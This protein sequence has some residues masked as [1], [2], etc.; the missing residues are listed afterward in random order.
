MLI[1]FSRPLICSIVVL[2]LS[3]A[4]ALAQSTLYAD[5]DAPPGGDGLSWN[6]AYRFLQDALADAAAS[7]G[8]ITE[9]RVAQGTYLPDRDEVNPGGDP[10]DC[11]APNGSPGCD[12]PACE[13]DV[14]AALAPCCVIDWD[15]NC[16]A[17]AADLCGSQCADPRL[18]T[19]QLLDGVSVVGGYA[20]LG[21]PDP[22][23]RLIE[24]YVTVLSGDILG[25][26]DTGGTNAENCYHVV[27]GSG[28]DATAVL[29]GFTVTAGN[30]NGPDP[31][32]SAG[33]GIVIASGDPTISQCWIT[34]NAAA[35]VGG[36][37]SCG[38]ASPTIS[39]CIIEANVA[40]GAIAVGGA[41]TNSE[42]DPVLIECE[43]IGN[44]ASSA[45][46]I[47]NYLSN[48]TF[49]GCR[50]EGNI[51]TGGD[52]G[53]MTNAVDSNPVL[54]DCQFI[55]NTA[56]GWGG[57]MLNYQ[58]S[59]AM[60][61]CTF[62]GNGSSS[63]G[64][65]LAIRDQSHPVLIDCVFT[66]NYG[67]NGGAIRNHNGSDPTLIGCSFTGNFTTQYG[68]GA[69]RSLTDCDMVLIACTFT[70]NSAV[71]NAGAIVNR[72]LSDPLIIGCT[73]DGNIS[74]ASAGAIHNY[75]VSNPLVVNSLFVG[76][77]AASRAGAVR[78]GALSSPTLINCTFTG[79][80]AG[81]AGGAVG[82][83]SDMTGIPGHASLHNCILWGNTAPLGA[84]IALNGIYPADVTVTYSDVEGGEAG[85]YVEPGFTLTWGP[86]N[87]D[88]DPLFADPAGGDYRLSGGSPCLDAGDNAAVP[89]DSEDLDEDGDVLEPMPYDL[90]DNPR[91]VDDCCTG[92]TGLGAPPIVDMGAYEFQRCSCDLDGNGT[93]DTVDFFDLLA[94]WGTDPGG[95]PDF[96][97]NGDVDVLDFFLLI[98][99]WG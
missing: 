1:R 80:S 28:T 27:T 24:T 56:A 39:S 70:G 38:L 19:F 55:A 67:T 75:D 53:A 15:A 82:A 32:T 69:I 2:A 42:S 50:F 11:C 72:A 73:F 95:P 40:T 81:E 62:S 46:A 3:V 85:V 48:P 77:S 78:A 87:I 23:E 89:P 25:D 9:I 18:A 30:A 60:T 14:C 68:G 92:D 59:P 84:E 61:G 49:T 36:G 41:M 86:G 96:D 33:G 31:P 43:F 4:P 88:A 54:T 16:A 57:A 66:D 17:L 97:G 12:D 20:G 64:G 90:D 51:A 37:I 83:G 79:N 47:H 22:N 94:Q 21:A 29:E 8:A 76:N 5:D 63:A 34:G 13:A 7:G 91:F 65:A 26:D 35:S 99:C 74:G 6:T 10:S 93:V 71:H 45:G 52:S 58:S 98:G 44:T